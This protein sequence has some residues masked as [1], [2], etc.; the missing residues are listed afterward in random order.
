MAGVLAS[1]ATR[2]NQMGSIEDLDL[3]RDNRNPEEDRRAT[4]PSLS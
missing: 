3:G 4:R 1:S 2:A